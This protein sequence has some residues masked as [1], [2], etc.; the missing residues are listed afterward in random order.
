MCRKDEGPSAEEAK[1]LCEDKVYDDIQVMKDLFLNIPPAE[2]E[3]HV[4][5]LRILCVTYNLMGQVFENSGKDS[6]LDNLLQVD[7]AHHDLYVIGTQ[8]AERP[9]AQSLFNASKAK[10]HEMLCSYFNAD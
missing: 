5:S 9:I 7:T 6:E 1:A 3:R 10:L 8:E 4:R 2:Y